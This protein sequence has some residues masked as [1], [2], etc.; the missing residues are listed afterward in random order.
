M[1]GD[2]DEW[3]LGVGVGV[4]WWWWNRVAHGG[5]RGPIEVV[6]RTHVCPVLGK[7]PGWAW[8]GCDARGPV[9]VGGL[10]GGGWHAGCR[11]A[12]LKH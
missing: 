6:G 1:S 8:C 12:A 2:E 10:V 7:E 9:A 11:A 5:E 3:G 4:G